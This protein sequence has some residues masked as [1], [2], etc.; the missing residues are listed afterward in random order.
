M[1]TLADQHQAGTDPMT[2]RTVDYHTAGEPFRIATRGIPPIPGD[3][4]LARRDHAIAHLD[5][6]RRLLVCE[7]RGHADMYGC[8]PVR[9][10]DDGALLGVLFFHNAGFSTACGHGTIALA[11][12]AADLG[13]VRPGGEAESSIAIDVPSGRVRARIRWA[14]PRAD[15]VTFRNVPSFVQAR[16][17][18]V[19]TSAG[20]LRADVAFGGAYYA[21]VAAADAGIPPEPAG[22]PRLITLGREIKR[23]LDEARAAEHPDEP[24]LS[25]IYG[26]TFT[27]P[28]TPAADGGP[29]VHQRNVTVFA[30]GEVDR[31]PCGSGTSARLALLDGSGD[32]KAGE[33][34]HHESVVGT[35]F[36]ARVTERV[37]AGGRAAVI[38][39]IEGRAFRT[40]E[41]RFTLDPRDDLGTGFILR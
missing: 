34:L 37:T 39:E 16:D 32:L 10:D 1:G 19:Q 17:V 3:T 36:T 33:P 29:G 24:R 38:T 15:A 12:W 21:S 35:R 30:D 9:P 40:G 2:V 8:F 23:A 26:V 6:Y 18:A 22:V 11:T 14:G 41:H 25:G 5:D 4:V 28:L 31:S 27:G 7:P 20:R 13:L